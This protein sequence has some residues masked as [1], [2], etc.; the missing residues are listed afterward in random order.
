MNKALFCVFK[1]S[2]D[3]LFDNLKSGKEN[4]NFCFQKKILDPKICTNLAQ[5]WKIVVM[6]LELAM[7][8][9]KMG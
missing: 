7:K 6:W 5:V 9:V 4:I 1:V 2:N 8:V 3:H